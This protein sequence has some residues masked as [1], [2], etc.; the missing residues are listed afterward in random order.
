[1]GIKDF[2]NTKP[3]LKGKISKGA[4]EEL[5]NLINELIQSYNLVSTGQDTSESGQEY[6]NFEFIFSR[7]MNYLNAY[8]SEETDMENLK[9][10]LIPKKKELTTP[11]HK[12]SFDL[13]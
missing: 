10:V 2:I 12:S 11:K 8:L 3:K 4:Q 13:E 7:I 1:M 6:H 5:R 9:L